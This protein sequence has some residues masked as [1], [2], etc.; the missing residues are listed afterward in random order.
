M[1]LIETGHM[2][3]SESKIT[4]KTINKCLWSW[5][6]AAFQ[7]FSWFF[8][9][10]QVFLNLSLLPPACL[11]ISPSLST[12]K[13]LLPNAFCFLTTLIFFWPPSLSQYIS[14]YISS[15]SVSLPDSFKSHNC[16]FLRARFYW[17]SLFLLGHRFWCQATLSFWPAHT[18]PA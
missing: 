11:S 12:L 4:L 17:L 9:I 14:L 18:L 7:I 1:G 15:A 16:H 3:V 10:L 2:W 13:L 5:T 8:L 6:N